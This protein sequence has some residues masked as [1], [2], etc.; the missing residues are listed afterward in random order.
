MSNDKP[1]RIYASFDESK[2]VIP[3]WLD[4]IYQGLA[5]KLYFARSQ[6]ELLL[7][8]NRCM[9]VKTQ[10]MTFSS[11]PRSLSYYSYYSY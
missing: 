5:S 9:N 4:V 6:F 3:V 7:K 8:G 2:A 1:L 10:V 11:M